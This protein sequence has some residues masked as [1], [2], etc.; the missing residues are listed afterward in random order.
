MTTAFPRGR[1]R[2]LKLRELFPTN[3]PVKTC[4]NSEAVVF[5]E[6]GQGGAVAVAIGVSPP[7]RQTSVRRLSGCPRDP[8]S[9]ARVGSARP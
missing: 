6:Q 1:S 9:E 7:T 8:R 4:C 5:N 3:L 2:M